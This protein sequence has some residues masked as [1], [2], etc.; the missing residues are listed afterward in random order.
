MAPLSP[1]T[2]MW[3]AVQ[4]ETI[5]GRAGIDSEKI[6]REKGLRAITIDAAWIMGRENDLGS[7]RAGKI[8]DFTVLAED[9]MTVDLDK[10]RAID[11][12]ATVHGGQPYPIKQP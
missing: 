2:L 1:L 12:I 6:S 10:L 11:I 7:I 5:N 4:R 8:A 3:T 9:P